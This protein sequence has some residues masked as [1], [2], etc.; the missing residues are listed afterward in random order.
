MVQGGRV[1]FGVPRRPAAGL[2]PVLTLAVGLLLV[3][4]VALAAPSVVPREPAP[5]VAAAPS[6]SALAIRPAA[7]PPSAVQF[8]GPSFD[9]E[10]ANRPTVEKPQSKLWF[11][12]G[13][14]WAAMVVIHGSADGP[15]ASEPETRS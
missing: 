3:V 10:P 14:W 15:H 7:Q 8:D 13:V 12:D 6:S 2:I 11:H 1:S 4:A 5:A 9:S